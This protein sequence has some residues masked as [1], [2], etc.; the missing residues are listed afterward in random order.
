VHSGSYFSTCF[1]P[2]TEEIIVPSS[3]IE[4]CML[5]PLSAVPCLS[6]VNF[7]YVPDSASLFHQSLHLSCAKTTA[8]GRMKVLSQICLTLNPRRLAYTMMPEILRWFLRASTRGS[9][10]HM[11]TLS[12]LPG[13]TPLLCSP[14]RASC[15]FLKHAI[16]VSCH[17]AFEQAQPTS[18]SSLGWH[19]FL[20]LPLWL[21]SPLSSHG[22]V[23][24]SSVC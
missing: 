18:L 12:I 6:Y 8:C 2:P 5:S 11:R 17:W 3:F 20:C 24:Q 4:W 1:F 13:L 14:S 21:V 22:A 7:L 16:A 19:F 15:S 23:I 10:L 9:T